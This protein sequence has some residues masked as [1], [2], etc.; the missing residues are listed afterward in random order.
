MRKHIKGTTCGKSVA[1]IDKAMDEAIEGP[2]EPGPDPRINPSL[3]SYPPGY[4]MMPGYSDYKRPRYDPSYQ[5]QL[6]RH[7]YYLVPMG[8]QQ[9]QRPQ[10]YP[11]QPSLMMPSPHLPGAPPH[12]GP[13]APHMGPG[14]PHMGSSH[15]MGPGHLGPQNNLYQ[16]THE[17]EAKSTSPALQSPSL[18]SGTDTTPLSPLK[19]E[20][21]P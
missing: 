10:M 7:Q 11:Q 14:A 15:M 21:S 20:Y 12:M 6:A 8:Q 17:A 5:E 13:G 3:A 18:I 4:G 9:P 1:D 19:R 16:A 2:S